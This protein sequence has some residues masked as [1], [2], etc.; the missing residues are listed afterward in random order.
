MSNQPNG[1][2]YRTTSNVVLSNSVGVVYALFFNYGG[3]HLA[4]FA[5]AKQLAIKS[6]KSAVFLSIRYATSWVFVFYVTQLI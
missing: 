5:R 2:I 4:T 1:E 6:V 3:V